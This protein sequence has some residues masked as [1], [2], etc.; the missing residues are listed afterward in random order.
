M[1]LPLWIIQE[2]VEHKNICGYLGTSKSS[3]LMYLHV[4]IY[5]VRHCKTVY[6]Y[7]SIAR[8]SNEQTRFRYTIW[9]S[10]QFSETR[11]LCCHLWDFINLTRL[12]FMVHQVNSVRRVFGVLLVKKVQVGGRTTSA[13]TCT[14]AQLCSCE[15]NLNMCT[16]GFCLPKILVNNSA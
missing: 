11:A 9:Q 5:Y 10:E 4:W 12:N 16:L 2:N 6:I 1:L 7:I 8:S 14:R 3:L 13:I 15:P